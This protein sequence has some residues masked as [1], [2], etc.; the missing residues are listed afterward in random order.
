MQ[1]TDSR[2]Y[3]QSTNS[4]GAGQVIPEFIFSDENMLEDLSDASLSDVASNYSVAMGVAQP[5]DKVFRNPYGS[6]NV[7]NTQNL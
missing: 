6:N 5:Q 2:P 7:S 1:P 4:N 3:T